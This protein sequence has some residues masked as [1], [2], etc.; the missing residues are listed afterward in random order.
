M[1]SGFIY[2]KKVFEVKQVTIT[3]WNKACKKNNRALKLEDELYRLIK[4]RRE[5]LEEAYLEG[6]IKIIIESVEHINGQVYGVLGGYFARPEK[7]DEFLNVL[8]IIEGDLIGI[9]YECCCQECEGFAKKML[10]DHLTL[11]KVK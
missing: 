7:S 10:K 8:T 9:D 1:E 6:A 3:E 4:Q 11:I 5:N 2:A